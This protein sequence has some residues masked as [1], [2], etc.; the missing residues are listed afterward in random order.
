MREDDEIEITPQMI[1]AGEAVLSSYEGCFSQDEM[2]R[3]VYTAMEQARLSLGHQPSSH[4][5]CL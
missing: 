3:A 1:G 5:V 2:A 4:P